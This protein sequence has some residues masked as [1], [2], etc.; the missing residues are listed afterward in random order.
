MIHMLMSLNGD[1]LS[2]DTLGALG[3][4]TSFGQM[5]GDHLSP[6]TLGALDM[7]TCFS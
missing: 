7:I 6:D 3:F 2:P 4:D 5:N 1:N